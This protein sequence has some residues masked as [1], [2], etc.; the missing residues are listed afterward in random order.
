MKINWLFILLILFTI[1]PIHSQ[2]NTWNGST[3]GDWHK[4]CNWSLN[5]IPTAA[6][7]V[8]IPTVGTYPTVTANAHCRT[9][10]IT[11]AATNAL[12]L[13]SSGGGNLC[14]SSTNGGACSTTATDNGGCAVP[15][16][17]WTGNGTTTFY[18]LYDC[19]PV[20]VGQNICRTF[21]N[22]TGYDITVN[23]NAF[24]SC[25]NR[26]SPGSFTIP[27]NGSFNFC[28]QQGNC[29]VCQGS[30][31]IPCP[32]SATWTS[33]DGASGTLTISLNTDN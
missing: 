4:E 12:T 28:I 32:T 17:A 2:T 1:K 27:A 30:I 15:G 29:C 16:S 11:T 18:N 10:N 26:S 25:T 8:T 21:S 9:L 31:I 22:N 14:I 23:Y 7:D 20:L 13:N 3:D 24:S 6:H 5:T 19:T 33:T